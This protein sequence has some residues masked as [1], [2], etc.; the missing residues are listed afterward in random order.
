MYNYQRLTESLNYSLTNF[1]EVVSLFGDASSDQT[2]TE[3]NTR[4]KARWHTVLEQGLAL[5]KFVGE[6]HRVQAPQVL[7][8]LEEMAKYA[9]IRRPFRLSVIGPKGVGKSALVNALLGATDIQYTPSEVAGK[10]VSGT[11]LRL[12]AR[13]EEPHAHTEPWRVVF[14]T[15]RRLWEIGLH[16]LTVSRAAT[17]P[18]TPAD[19]NNRQQVLQV[20]QTTLAE[21]AAT[22]A[23]NNQVGQLGSTL[24]IQATNARNTLVE[25]LE[26]YQNYAPQMPAN[27]QLWVEDENVDGPISSYIRQAEDKLY[28]II[29]YVERYIPASQA[30]F[31]AGR[32]LELEDVLGLDDPRDSF[33]ALEA[34]KEAFAVIMVFK[35]DRGLNTESSSLLANLFSR[36]EE[37]LAQFGA[38]AD[39]NKAIVVA[40]QFDNITSNV[41]SN[42]TA[43]PLKGIEDIQ[44]ELNRYTRQPVPVYLTSAEMS[45]HASNVLRSNGGRPSQGYI[46]Y[47]YGLANL[48]QVLDG[49]DLT[50]DYLDF[51]LAKRAEIEGANLE[52]GGFGS[53]ERARLI[54]EMS[55]LP[56]LR[57]KVQEALEASSILRGRVANAEYYY[58]QAV[59]ETALCYAR[60][61]QRYKLDLSE[62]SQPPVSIE[63]RLFSKFQHEMRQKLEEVDREFRSSYFFTT[64]QRYIHGAM[65]TEIE[66][67]RT[68]FLD[69]VRN[70]IINNQNLIQ[71]EQHISTGQLVTDAWRKVFEDIN[72]WLALEASRQLRS[73]V[74]PILRD[75][76]NLA[77]QMQKQLTAINTNSPL[78]ETFWNGYQQR[79]VRLRQRLQTQAEV[80]AL[81]YYT[82][83]RFSVYDLQIAERLHVGDGQRRRTEVIKLMQE[84][85]L[86]WFNN[87]W[88]LLTKVVMTDLSA[89]MGEIR[90]Y[91]LG[92]PADGSL[93]VG[94]ELEGGLGK[95]QLIPEE[96]LT[97]L[98]NYQYHASANFRR[99]YAL[100]E[101][102]AAERLS[103][104]IRAWLEVLAQA[105]IDG[106]GELNKAVAM[107]G[108]APPENFMGT[109]T[110]SSE[111]TA[112][113]DIFTS[114]PVKTNDDGE[115]DEYLE[116]P[117][118]AAKEVISIPA[119]MPTPSNL[120]RLRVPIES[121]HPYGRIVRQV[122]EFTNPDTQA[123]YTRL[124]FSRIDLG[125]AG[126][127]DRIVL[128]SGSRFE[129]VISGQQQD[130]WSNPYPGRTVVIRFFADNPKPGWGFI[131]DAAESVAAE[132]AVSV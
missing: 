26:V 70:V 4:L 72:D 115:Y 31:L 18:K 42:S 90:H 121:N 14:L 114:G 97:A 44:R 22:F 92:L 35:C 127:G 49:R 1:E 83:N 15:P 126:S 101:P 68:A 110:V 129:Q 74:G 103:L 130:F 123:T 20:F 27:Y 16:L 41:D 94:L 105:G 111:A 45:K 117:P 82:D 107:V 46:G 11:R 84:R 23:A 69:T 79:L 81:A 63:S 2:E 33:F 40:N 132:Q 128:S 25:M 100:R 108:V 57:A 21:T 66:Q 120:T 52:T 95:G 5:T 38:P 85:V 116:T 62:F 80:L 50:P 93:L 24:Q 6:H 118:P 99:Q 51:V 112:P 10:A 12:M 29:D 64:A 55:G 109:E 96:S 88:H 98:L 19:L 53:L 102:T 8:S 30:G 43:N 77:A 56:R 75:V 124:H 59:S 71:M 48:L 73:L 7:A 37:K 119:P 67:T 28:L 89:F 39:L 58:A 60:Q 47:L 65:P 106:L 131:L 122:W 86:S 9:D 125:A 34:F 104:E 91:V 54:L 32:R 113:D 87:M 61:M 17:L 76:D 36:D 3:A 13:R 78:D